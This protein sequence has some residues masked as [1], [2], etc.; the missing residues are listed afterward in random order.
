MQM[1]NIKQLQSEKINQTEFVIQHDLFVDKYLSKFIDKELL[2]NLSITSEKFWLGL[3]SIVE[4]FS[5][6]NFFLLEQRDL[7]QKKIDDWCNENANSE[8]VIEDYILQLKDMGYLLPEGKPFKIKT[9]NVDPEVSRTA[10]PQ[11]V[12]PVSNA[13]FALNAC[14]ARWGSLYDA[15][16][17]SDLIPNKGNFKQGKTYNRKRGEHV[18]DFSLNFLNRSIPL[19]SASHHDVSYYLL[20]NNQGVG[21]F[22]AVLNDGE[23]SYLRNQEK[24]LGW[25]QNKDKTSYLFKNNDLHIELIIDPMHPI[26][27]ISPGNISDIILESAV[28]IILDCEDSVA[29]V[30]SEDKVNIYRNCLE[31]MLGTLSTE[32]EKSGLS[33][34]R[35]LNTDRIYISKKY[36]EFSVKG[37]ALMFTRNVGSHMKTDIVLNQKK[38]PI[39]E[40][41]LDAIITSGCSLAGMKDSNQFINSANKS[42]Y[43]VKPKLH[44]P[45]ECS[46]FNELLF[47][48]E[49]LFDLPAN[50][51]KVGLMD[52]ERR[53]SSNLKECI[54]K[55]QHR[56]VFINT[57]FLD[58]TGDEIHTN[59]RLG[60]V[61]V[62]DK[63]KEDIWYSSYE[64]NNVSTAINCGF[65]GRAQIGK[66]MWAKPDEYKEMMETKF[67]QLQS[68]ASCAWVP[69]PT[70][71]TLHAIHYHD[72]YVREFQNQLTLQKNESLIKSILSPSI[73]SK[74]SLDISGIQKELDSNVQSILGYVVHWINSGVGCSKVLDI[75]NI[76][77]MEDR[78][79]LRISCQHIANWLLHGICSK[80]QVIDS[81]LR[82]A[83]YVDDQ[84]INNT[85]YIKLKTNEEN[86]LAYRAAYELIFN[87]CNS[88]NG[89]TEEILHKYR[90]LEKIRSN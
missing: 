7:L 81:L 70:A 11:L 52:E 8:Y 40:G 51:I 14:N 31:L 24:F 69:S 38:E 84:N 57:G 64:K 88:P 44:G 67:H 34:T 87:G 28:S 25:T 12:V 41:L 73:T 43:I 59:M 27:K 4:K 45:D 76:F 56:I 17:G 80:D 58:R 86:S 90:K 6:L 55:L 65:I 78:A 9:S 72:Y 53:T 29:A 10:A 89:Y 71:A 50:T 35:S 1:D 36:K 68:G 42:I 33:F 77:L 61:V 39:Y 32:I 63:I 79:T 85:Y 26:G 15:V 16:Y 5:P 66:G 37:R 21:F 54:R 47:E 23:I 83:S 60:P 48:I 19:E 20:E 46:F 13:R 82:M 75:K 49:S 3:S 2:P 74:E 18:I 22:S 30:D 62:K